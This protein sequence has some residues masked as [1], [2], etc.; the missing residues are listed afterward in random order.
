MKDSNYL[1]EMATLINNVL[2][3]AELVEELGG[4]QQ[5]TKKSCRLLNTYCQHFWDKATESSKSH[6][7][8][9]NSKFGS[10]A[11]WVATENQKKFSAHAE[12]Q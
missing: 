8:Q 10:I 1:A 3:C 6:R 9:T 12:S 11:M 5:T 4:S 7:I 2:G